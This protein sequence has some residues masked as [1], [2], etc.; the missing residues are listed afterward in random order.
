MNTGGCKPPAS[1]RVCVWCVFVCCMPAAG[2]R[3]LTAALCRG[4]LFV[5][6]LDLVAAV[7]CSSMR[8]LVA[9]RPGRRVRGA[10]AP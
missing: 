10:G 4:L 6:V 5:F 7:L 1:A 9:P 2:G 3:G 8:A